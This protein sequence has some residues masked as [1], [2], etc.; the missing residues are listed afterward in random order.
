MEKEVPHSSSVTSLT[1]LVETPSTYI[2]IKA[3]TAPSR[4]AGSGRT[5]AWRRS[6]AVLGHQ[7]VQGAHPG[8]Q[9]LGL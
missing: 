9:V 7:E 5:G 1:F 6:F 3:K 2:S 8:P 4:F